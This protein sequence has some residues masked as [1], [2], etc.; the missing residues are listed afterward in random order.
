MRKLIVIYL[1]NIVKTLS[2]CTN[3]NIKNKETINNNDNNLNELKK[4]YYNYFTTIYSSKNI[5]NSKDN[6]KMEG[7]TLNIKDLSN[8]N[9]KTLIH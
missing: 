6:S 7:N 2:A 4:H 8:K 3:T 9:S 1:H 5:I